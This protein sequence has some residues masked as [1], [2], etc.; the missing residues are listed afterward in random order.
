MR[1]YELLNKKEPPQP[2]GPQGPQD[3]NDEEDS[4]GKFD[5]DKVDNN[6]QDISNDI[7][8][9]QAQPEPQAPQQSPELSDDN[10]KPIDDALMAQ[11]KSLPYSKK[12]QFDYGSPLNAINLAQSSIEDLSYNQAKVRYK[13]QQITNQLQVGMDDDKTMEFCNDL[14]RLLNTIMHFKKTNTKSQLA[15]YNHAPAYQTQK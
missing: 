4:Q 5:A 10:T 15:A 1:L 9:Q 7:N 2:P 12:Y 13:M 14:M 8:N 11:I 3:G 6:L